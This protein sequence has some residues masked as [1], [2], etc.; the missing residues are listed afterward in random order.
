MKI[1]ESNSQ[2]ADMIM[3]EFL[4][5]L[6][7][8]LTIKAS[9][10][11]ARIKAKN[12]EIWKKTDTYW[13]LLNGT[14]NHEFGFKKG[15]AEGKVNA[16]LDAMS[17]SIGVIPVKFKKR[18]LD[19]VGLRIYV[20]RRS[21]PDDI[22]HMEE[23]KVQTDEEKETKFS[24][25]F[26][27]FSGGSSIDGSNTTITR[28]LPWLNWLLREGNSFIILNYRYE[29]VTSDRSRSGKGLMIPDDNENWK[30]PTEYSGTINSHWLIRAL[31]AERK[32]LIS[33]YGRIINEVLE[34]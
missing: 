17:K 8:E 7:E 9:E 28:E 34:S 23:A 2:I 32:H 3:K 18:G 14:L 11:S 33:E 22:F 13:S 10:I 5:Q 26:A 4:R 1:L 31:K 24:N 25:D 12:I 19:Y 20:L 16:V 27:Q 6:H 29:P 15:T 21:I 30:V